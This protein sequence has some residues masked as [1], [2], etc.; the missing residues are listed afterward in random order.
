LGGRYTNNVQQGSNTIVRGDKR[1]GSKG[2]GDENENE[3][4]NKN[5]RGREDTTQGAI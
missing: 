5:K 3:N 4:E 2:D 1:Q